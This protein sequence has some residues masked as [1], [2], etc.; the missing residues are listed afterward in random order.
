MKVNIEET[1]S[2]PRAQI[3]KDWQ[4]VYLR[5]QAAAASW[6]RVPYPLLPRDAK[7]GYLGT[8]DEND[9]EVTR[10]QEARVLIYLWVFWWE[11]FVGGKQALL[12]KAS[13]KIFPG[14]IQFPVKADIL[15]S[16]WHMQLFF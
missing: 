3:I 2:E 5:S 10:G 11:D 1:D 12:E 7:R 16:I 15:C 13:G 4:V 6:H 9:L 8:C 14:Q